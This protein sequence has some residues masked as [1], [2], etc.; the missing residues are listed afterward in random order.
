[1]RTGYAFQKDIVADE[2]AE[3]QLFVEIIKAGNLSAAARAL[4]SSPAAMSRGLSALESRLGVRLVTRTSRTF[5]LTEEGQ[6]FYERCERIV[7]EIAEAE[8]EASSQG[9]TVKGK[10]RIGAPMSIGRRL[11]APLIARFVEKYPGIEAHLD[12]SDSGLDV[13]DDGL[14][15][16]LRAGLPTDASVIAKKILST[17]RAVCASPSYLKRH[18]I[19][20]RPED[21]QQHDCIRLVRGRRVMDTWSFQENGKRFELTVNGALTTN[22]GEVM[23]NW[24]RAGRGIALKAVWDVQPDLEAGTLVEC[25]REFWCDEIDLFAICANRQHLFPR[26]RV[27]LDFISA[28]LPE[29]VRKE[30][31]TGLQESSSLAEAPFATL[32]RPRKG[33]QAET[34]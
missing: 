32:S 2:V 14:D 6:L 19:P 5:A 1:M 27:F 17:R 9:K 30:S 21:L 10:L 18:G 24:V 4:N 15:V 33:R 3:L 13:I 25:L 34:D 28:T 12:L 29:M 11:I 7:E 31:R 22:S 26:I 20:R 23:H 8:A 16:A